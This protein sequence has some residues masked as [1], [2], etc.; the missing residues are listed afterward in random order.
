MAKPKICVVGSANIDLISTVS[1]LPK[2]GETLSGASFQMSF[3]GKGANQAVMAA[4]L[5]GHVVM[6]TKL[7]QDIFGQDMLKNFQQWGVDTEFVSFTAA[8]FSGTA[9]IAVDEEGHNSIIVVPGAN[10]LLTPTDV[11]A[12]R[13]AIAAA[14]VLVC[15]LEIPLETTL[16]ALRLARKAGV[17]T[18]FNPAPAQAD[19]PAELYH[20]SDILCPN[21]TETELLTSLSVKSL[22]EAEAAA[23]V[24]L[25]R[26]ARQ[27]ILTLGERGS[28]LVSAEETTHVAVS[29][30]KVVDTTGAGDAFIGSLAYFLAVGQPLIEAIRQ[31]NQIAAI[32]VQGHGTQTSYPLVSD[33]PRVLLE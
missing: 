6:V 22:E 10:D 20:L 1:H 3:G 2:R 27:V 4:K 8:A 29:P 24:L 16:A 28:L 5:G 31:A 33:L 21:E 12:V 13:P 25:A 17:T 19:L 7:G 11:E 23:R 32:S 18:L 15:Q 30:V 9:S 26:G 14:D